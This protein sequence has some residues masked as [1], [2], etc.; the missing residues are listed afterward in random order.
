MD[1]V[2]DTEKGAVVGDGAGAVLEVK[3]PHKKREQIQE[4][5]FISLRLQ[6]QVVTV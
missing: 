1:N 2:L 4:P 3:K 6:Q 5:P